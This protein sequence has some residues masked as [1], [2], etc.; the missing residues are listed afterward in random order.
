[1][2]KSQFRST[3]DVKEFIISKSETLEK[4][5]TIDCKQDFTVPTPDC[6][7]EFIIS[8]IVPEM[9]NK[10]S[11]LGLKDLFKVLLELSEAGKSDKIKL[12]CALLH[13]GLTAKFPK[14]DK[15]AG[16]FK[17]RKVGF[18]PKKVDDN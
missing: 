18:K 15:K 1:M 14:K 6:F 11:K 4:I 9:N 16:G 12:A 17:P 5:V 3:K 10:E 13:T 7:D 8:I 2:N